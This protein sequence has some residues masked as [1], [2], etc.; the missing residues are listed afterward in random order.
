MPCWRLGLADDREV[1]VQATT[2]QGP[3]K[4]FTAVARI[5]TPQEARYYQHGGI[6]P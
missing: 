6:L 2:E 4:T 5:D 3:V 1:T